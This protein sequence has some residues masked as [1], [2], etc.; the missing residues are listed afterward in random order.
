MLLC[1]V[2]SRAARAQDDAPQPPVKVLRTYLDA[3]RQHQ[4]L[5]P[6]LAE[7]VAAP[8]MVDEFWFTLPPFKKAWSEQKLSAGRPQIG[9]DGVSFV[10]TAQL[11]DTSGLAAI[12]KTIDAAVSYYSAEEGKKKR[13]DL[14]L[15]QLREASWT[16]LDKTFVVRLQKTG[17]VWKI[18]DTGLAAPLP[19]ANT[20]AEVAPAAE[21]VDDTPPDSSGYRKPTPAAMATYPRALDIVRVEGRDM[22][23]GFRCRI[24]ATL[25]NN[26]KL[27]VRRVTATVYYAAGGKELVDSQRSFVV[28]GVLCPGGTQPFEAEALAPG[29]RPGFSGAV[30]LELLSVEFDQ[31]DAF[32]KLLSAGCGAP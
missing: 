13:R 1:L 6:L 21:V 29:D 15:S 23:S 24:V 14:A 12:G 32:G 30:R 3:Y 22:D 25:K 16:Y 5:A 9:D 18:S 27:P 8:A 28:N 19:A 7:G 2:P 10:V 17:A 26:G 31:P 20:T 4:N 11:L